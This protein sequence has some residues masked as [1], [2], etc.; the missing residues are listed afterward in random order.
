MKKRRII[1][2]IILFTAGIAAL[3]FG[4]F[5]KQAYPDLTALTDDS[6]GQTVNVLM[7]G[8]LPINESDYL[9]SY[10]EQTVEIRAAV[11]DALHSR[12]E[13][14]VEKSVPV[15][16]TVRR[17]TDEMRDEAYQT[18]LDYCE[19]IASYEDS[20]EVTDDVRSQIRECIS[21]YYIEVTAV[22]SNLF[23]TVMQ[24]SF[25][26]GCTLLFFAVILLISIL[27]GK[28]FWKILLIILIILAIPIIIIGIIFFNKIRTVCSI[29]KDGD[30]V[31]Y[32]EYKGEY[33]LD[34]ML[35]AGITS[36][37]AFSDWIQKAEFCNLP[38]ELRTDRFG[39]SSFKAKTPDGDVLFG[40]NFD[41]A[42]T[43]T[44]MIYS[45][46]E[47]GY[48][49]YSMAD[50]EVLGIKP[51]HGYYDAD[52]LIGRILML[53]APYAAC[54]GVN[55]A[56][57]G[58]STLELSIGEIHQDTGKPDLF[59]YNAIRLLLD[60]CA[61]VE[62][63]LDLLEKYD[64][65][66]HNNVRQHLFIADKSGRSVVVEWFDD[67]MYVNELDA[68]TNSVLT[69]GELYGEGADDRLPTILAGLSEHNG[70]LTPEQ[71]RDLLAAAAQ[72][73]YTEWSCVYDLNKF[74]ADVY[75]DEKFDHAYHYE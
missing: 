42:E 16:G 65:H 17:C 5:G 13:R 49:S 53:A 29:R 52:T 62:E 70:I 36:D 71:A 15:T 61:N 3:L 2:A 34:D 19:M 26:A 73:D 43:D 45:H 44:L 24:I 10:D 68:V 4:I 1:T 54:D 23:T 46:P 58:V 56:G 7:E 33:K 48:A 41:Y 40:R 20:F 75:V 25:I 60:R 31:Y 27:S 64:I 11:P 55:E 8:P 74:T 38:I 39:C 14:Y 18:L 63:A 32:M 59:V 67:Q 66:S 37:K 28:S 9:I 6:I 51:K 12:F 21:Q 30:G 50:L 35:N 22:N 72:K 47:N 57:L 69:P